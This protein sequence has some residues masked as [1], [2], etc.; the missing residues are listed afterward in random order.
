VKNNLFLT[1]TLFLLTFVLFSSSRVAFAND[2][3][4]PD[5]YAFISCVSDINEH[6]LGVAQIDA[7]V[8]DDILSMNYYHF[9]VD[10]F[11]NSEVDV[12]N[13]SPEA[14]RDSFVNKLKKSADKVPE[15]K[16]FVV[17]LNGHM[18]LKNGILYYPLVDYDGKEGSEEVA[19]CPAEE[20]C[21]IMR[22]CRAKV[23]ILFID[24]CFSG[25]ET[26]ET[27]FQGDG[28]DFV[29]FASSQCWQT[30][31]VWREKRAS[32]FT[33]WLAF[34][35][36]GY[37]DS[38]KDG[39]VSLDE[40]KRYVT[41]QVAETAKALGVTQTP[42]MFN[43]EAAG[44]FAFRPNPMRLTER[45]NEIAELI[46]TDLAIDAM[47]NEDARKI[48]LCVPEF[49]TGN[50]KA[51]LKTTS[52]K[53]G[54]VP[55][56][57]ASELG[58]KMR[59]LTENWA[60][61]PIDGI[62]RWLSKKYGYEFG[63]I[64]PEEI[65]DA[66]RENGAP[67]GASFDNF[68]QMDEKSKVAIIEKAIERDDSEPQDVDTPRKNDFAPIGKNKKL[69]IIQVNLED[70]DACGVEISA[71]IIFNCREEFG[72]SYFCRAIYGAS[73]L[74][75][76]GNNA[77][78]GV[79]PNKT[80]PPIAGSS[81]TIGEQ[82][83]KMT[84]GPPIPPPDSSQTDK[85]NSDSVAS[86]DSSNPPK[87]EPA[88]TPVVVRS[89]I[90]DRAKKMAKENK[91]ETKAEPAKPHPLEEE[92]RQYDV[93]FMSRPISSEWKGNEGYERV[94]MKFKDGEAFVEFAPEAEYAIVVENQK[95]SLQKKSNSL[96]GSVCVRITV[97]GRETIS[98][99]PLREVNDASLDTW[100]QDWVRVSVDKAV[101]WLVKPK[102]KVY[103]CGF[104][105]P[106]LDDPNQSQLRRFQVVSA[107]KLGEERKVYAEKIGLITFQIHN[108][109]D[110]ERGGEQDAATLPRSTEIGKIDTV[111]ATI[112]D[113]IG[114]FS[115]NYR[116]KS[117]KKS[118]N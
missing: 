71:K 102:Q 48:V 113:V 53:A 115:V 72:R 47:N 14:A 73:D 23:K 64:A 78:N 17:Y 5:G 32:L 33:Y 105:K 112:G 1:S 58:K 87:E 76:M 88:Y 43:S 101:G 84:V 65:E 79:L 92:K 2:N 44:D 98:F 18:F 26:W 38:N 104:S 24:C 106:N 22:A 37:A 96:G 60:D 99:K 9:Q 111:D 86:E 103:V 46:V 28:S 83:E 61:Y 97:D 74:A 34:G 57:R 77:D 67:I 118:D 109:G 66:L 90:E 69:T 93:Y 70:Y 16:P 100:R 116:L 89:L 30:S 35:L 25:S 12:S 94:E 41:K 80:D 95:S 7:G 20:I 42:Q 13:A 114:V 10:R 52:P 8:L 91:S 75:N 6:E 108:A 55:R 27:S 85:T 11:N 107:D 19:A 45:L 36:R 21:E 50:R 39:E 51:E 59:S 54:S 29:T 110:V 40:L 3:D 4:E 49:S 56:V 117:D 62:F 82:I 81:D 63:W 31:K 68:D 15:D